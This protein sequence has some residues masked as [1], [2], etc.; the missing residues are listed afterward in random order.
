MIADNS[1]QTYTSA[2]ARLRERGAVLVISL[3]ILMVMTV[4]GVTAMRGT[5]LEERMAGNLRDG[6]LAFEAAE[7]A[8]RAASEAA[9]SWT[10]IPPAAC[11]GS[12][13]IFE[14]QSRCGNDSLPVSPDASDLYANGNRQDG[15]VQL[16]EDEIPGVAVQPMYAI[17]DTAFVPDDLSP[18]GLA[19]RIG[20]DYYAVTALGLGST[21]QSTA[22][23]QAVIAKRFN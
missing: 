18:E 6:V 7:A 13:E 5:A 8:L 10:S 9:D 1:S 21:E 20:T 2:D 22:M 16:P 11:D 17:Q 12:Q 14:R 4:V 3:V 23:L 19:K 15:V